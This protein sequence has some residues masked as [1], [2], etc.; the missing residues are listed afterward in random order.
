MDG[1]FNE[2][3]GFSDE[4]SWDSLGPANSADGHVDKSMFLEDTR[5]C[6]VHLASSEV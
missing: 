3:V 4:T 1:C 2:A 6:E 5:P